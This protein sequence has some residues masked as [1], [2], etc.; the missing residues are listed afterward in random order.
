MQQ[1]ATVK[2]P[3]AIG[4]R[5]VRTSAGIVVPQSALPRRLIDKGGWRKV[6]RALK[7]LGSKEVGLQLRFWCAECDKPVSVE[8][9]EELRMTCGCMVR[10]VR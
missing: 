1:A 5:E 6:R 2:R 8:L 4:A 3:S 9:D 7:V 10:V